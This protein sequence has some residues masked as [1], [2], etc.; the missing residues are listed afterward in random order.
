MKKST[1]AILGLLIIELGLMFGMLW[2]VAQVRTGTW[3]APDPGKAIATITATCG[4]AM[5]IVGAVLLIAF[6]R[7]RIRGE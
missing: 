3:H 6:I 5:G 7:F 4:G 1:R 2:M